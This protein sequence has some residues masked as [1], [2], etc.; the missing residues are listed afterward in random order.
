MRTGGQN[1]WELLG[2]GGVLLEQGLF[3]ILDNPCKLAWSW[4]IELY[5]WA[6]EGRSTG[7]LFSWPPTMSLASNFVGEGN[8]G[9]ENLRQKTVRK[10]G[11]REPEKGTKSCRAVWQM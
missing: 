1:S 10:G 2:R 8:P 6:P 5:A 11:I 4:T 9:R 3:W 7:F